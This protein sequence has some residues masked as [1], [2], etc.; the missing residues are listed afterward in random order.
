MKIDDV[1]KLAEQLFRLYG[2]TADLEAL[3]HADKL[4]MLGD[5]ANSAKW[6]H[7]VDRVR[8]MQNIRHVP[9]CA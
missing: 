6:L 5:V 1:E 2:A 7:V 8:E 9:R 3:K 4:R